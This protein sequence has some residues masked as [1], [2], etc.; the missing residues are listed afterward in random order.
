[1][2]PCCC[3]AL[4][5]FDGKM[6]K[7]NGLY[8]VS[9]NDW[10]KLQFPFYTFF[11]FLLSSCKFSQTT[12]QFPSHYTF[13]PR[14]IEREWNIISYTKW[15]LKHF[16]VNHQNSLHPVFQESMIYAIFQK[17]S[18][19]VFVLHIP[20]GYSEVIE[21]IARLQLFQTPQ[22]TAK[23]TFFFFSFNCLSSLDI[24]NI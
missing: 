13:H 20:S 2:R 21:F 16:S 19:E 23:P 7:P 18:P 10:E 6:S 1:M 15:P 17:L 24:A 22:N 5:R 9:C 12:N 8:H 14:Q 3:R 4:E 11:S